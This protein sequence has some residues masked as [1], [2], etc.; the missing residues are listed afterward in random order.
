MRRFSDFPPQTI[1]DTIVEVLSTY[2]IPM[3]IIEITEHMGEL[4]ELTEPI[5]SEQQQQVQQTIDDMLQAGRLNIHDDKYIIGDLRKNGDEETYHVVQL[6][7]PTENTILIN[8]NNIIN[9]IGSEYYPEAW[10]AV[11]DGEIIVELIPEPQNP[12]DSNAVAVTTKNEILGH[13]TRTQ[14]EHYSSAITQLNEAGYSLQVT[15]EVLA[16]PT[17]PNYR[18]IQLAMPSTQTLKKHTFS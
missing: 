10:N 2:D 3:S 7:S 8:G 12:Y 17:D 6:D 9:T 5:H 15:G 1:R 13:L 11:T 14:A 16:S 4:L 18:Y